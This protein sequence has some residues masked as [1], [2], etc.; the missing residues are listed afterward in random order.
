MFASSLFWTKFHHCY[1]KDQE[2]IYRFFPYIL[3]WPFSVTVAHLVTPW[4][5]LSWV[6][7]GNVS[8]SCVLD[9]W[10]IN[11]VYAWHLIIWLYH[12]RVKVFFISSFSQK[13]IN[14]LSLLRFWS[15]QCADTMLASKARKICLVMLCCFATAACQTN[16]TGKLCW[17]F[18]FEFWRTE[19]VFVSIPTNACSQVHGREWLGCRAAC[20][21]VS[22]CLTRGGS[23]GMCNT[24]T[25]A[26][27]E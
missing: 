24:Y 8:V 16:L 2:T 23:L 7:E 12:V 17:L 15:F 13:Q 10:S 4:L 18:Y 25:S 6:S 9:P 3:F 20:Q 11:Y 26:K 27:F 14:G 5:S 1:K 19:V 22:K 21:D